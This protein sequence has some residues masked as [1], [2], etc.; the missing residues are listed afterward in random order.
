[1]A[2]SVGELGGSRPAV[3]FISCELILIVLFNHAWLDFQT[4]LLP[5]FKCRRYCF[6]AN[7]WCGA[8]I[9]SCLGWSGLSSS[10]CWLRALLDWLRGQGDWVARQPR[11]CINN[12]WLFGCWLSP[13][14]FW[15][16]GKTQLD[17]VRRLPV[18]AGSV[19]LDHQASDRSKGYLALLGRR[20]TTRESIPHG[21]RHLLVTNSGIRGT[22]VPIIVQIRWH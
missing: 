3:R 10:L 15:H 1:L 17:R 19:L 5:I 4:A 6:L 12:G 22:L 21:H 20:R 16:M 7:F 14:R 11:H 18:L 8:V 13:L 9:S 2:A